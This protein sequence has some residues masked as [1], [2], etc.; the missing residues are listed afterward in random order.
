VNTPRVLW[1]SPWLRPLARVQTEE[2][3]RRGV[4][5]LLVTTDA[6]PESDLARDYELVLDTRFRSAASWPPALS[7]WRRVRAFRPD[8][9]V[10]EMVRDPRWIALA[11]QVP[12]IQLIHDHRPH[13]AAENR[14]AYEHAVFD[15]WGARSAATVT[16]S[17]YVAGAVATRPDVAGT[18][19]Y[20]V[21]LCSDLDTGLVPPFVAAEG[22]RDFVMVGRLFPYKNLDVVL[23]SWQRHV[24]GDSWR[25]DELVII[26]DGPTLPHT[27]LKHTRALPGRYR[28]SDI[29]ATVAA[30]KGSVVHHR[31]ASQSGVQVLSMQLGVTPMVSVSGGLPEYQTPGP[32][33]IGVDDVAG[34][35]AVFDELADPDTGA[36]RG[37]T[38]ARHYANTF[39]VACFAD[40]FLNVINEVLAARSPGRSTATPTALIS[41]S[42]P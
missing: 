17:D 30:A 2:L 42:A 37:A 11:G 35:T 3:R 29:V 7:A 21:S 38:A 12:R 18:C 31:H 26:G 34:L 22:R 13:D 8:V 41:R 20:T 27:L 5:V 39:S 9:V 4:D 32:P 1:L 25:G 24:A 36:A 6:H 23:E 19:M 33:P 40:Q 16:F 10:A 28:Y 15:R 14:P